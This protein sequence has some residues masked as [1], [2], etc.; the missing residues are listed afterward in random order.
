VF[1][2]NNTWAGTTA[3]AKQ[4]AAWCGSILAAVH[5]INVLALVHR[6]MKVNV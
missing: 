1:H 2:Y 4:M 3:Q 6:S 5:L